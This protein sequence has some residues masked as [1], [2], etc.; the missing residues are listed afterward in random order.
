MKSKTVF[1]L[2]CAMVMA[3]AVPVKSAEVDFDQGIDLTDVM[4]QVKHG[5]Y[6][7]DI[8]EIGSKYT[9]RFNDYTRDCAVLTFGPDDPLKS[10]GVWLRSQEWEEYCDY[11]TD[12]NGHQI[13]NCHT[14]P[15]QSWRQK[16]QI[17]ITQDRELLPWEIEA[18]EVCLEGPWMNIYT[19]AAAYKYHINSEGSYNTIYKLTPQEKT[20]MAPDSAGLAVESF[21]YNADDKNFTLNTKDIWTDYYQGEQVRIHAVL[22]RDVPNWFDSKIGELDMTFD[23][24][25][26]YTMLL[27]FGKKL[28]SGK[29]Y[30][31][32]GFTRI[33]RVSTDK[34]IKKGNTSERPEVK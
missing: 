2:L 5:D 9:G 18:F 3:I 31:K 22:Y 29:Y 8:P 25:D 32:W 20:P 13:P 17:I 15:G 27:D 19:R 6:E 16:A 1:A 10:E 30:A 33:G 14:V 21:V 12:P 26:G 7:Y 4:D 34:Y 24:A 23:S 28:K 11:Y